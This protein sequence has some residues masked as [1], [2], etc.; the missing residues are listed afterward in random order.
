MQIKKSCENCGGIFETTT[1]NTKKKYCSDSCK[2]QHW[3]KR[4]GKVTQVVVVQ[5]QPKV[6]EVKKVEPDINQEKKDFLLNYVA[7]LPK[8]IPNPEYEKVS[9]QITTI[10]S[11]IKT[12]TQQKNKLVSKIEALMNRNQPLIGALI[13]A[14]GGA[15]TSFVSK[16]NKFTFGLI[17]SLIGGITGFLIGQHSQNANEKKVW[18]EIDNLNNEIAKLNTQIQTEENNLSHWVQQE[19]IIGYL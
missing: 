18:L 9:A 3:K 10:K 1:S 8:K 14:S 7:S 4:N 2:V 15:L 13:G 17:G 19:K 6:Q 16:D 12:Y 11:K 5:E